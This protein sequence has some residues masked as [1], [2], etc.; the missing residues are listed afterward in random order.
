MALT[1]RPTLWP[2]VLTVPAI[3]VLIFLG[4]WQMDR[5]AWKQGLIEEMEA[6]LA[7]PSVTLPAAIEMPEAWEFRRIH[8]RGIFLHEKE[9]YLSSRTHK[10][11]VGY[12]IVTPLKREDGAALLVNRGWVPMD[13]KDPSTR[14]SGLPSGIVTVKG[15][16]RTDK[17]KG[18]LTPLNE[19][20]N[21]LWF[22]VDLPAMASWAEVSPAV[23]VLLDADLSSDPNTYPLAFPSRIEVANAHLHYAITW[24]LL[25]V[26]LFVI[27]FLYHQR[28]RP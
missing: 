23:P 18:W 19:P 5:L 4:N 1:F 8:V 27:Y 10:G 7:V 3:L 21:N 13:Q 16:L 26:I 14:L 9:M 17:P 12:G 25:A 22:H 20:G 24:Y 15:V 11:S 6:N 28:S 2:T